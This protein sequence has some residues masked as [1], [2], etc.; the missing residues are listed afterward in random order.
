MIIIPASG[1]SDKLSQITSALF[2]NTTQVDTVK[3][4]P[5]AILI[6]NKDIEEYYWELKLIIDL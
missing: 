6:I 2:L 5:L 3:A 1:L 4:N